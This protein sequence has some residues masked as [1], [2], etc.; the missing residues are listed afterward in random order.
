ME[1]RLKLNELDE[2]II[3]ELDHIVSI[4]NENLGIN[5]LE[6]NRTRPYIDGRKLLLGIMDTRYDL[7]NPGY[8]Y[9]PL[10]LKLLARYMGYR[11]HATAIHHIKD[12]E[13]LLNW[14]PSYKDIIKKVDSITNKNLLIRKEALEYLKESLLSQLED[15]NQKLSELNGSE[16][17]N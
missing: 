6:K 1:K 13:N 14:E 5:I 10:T 11:D 3:K 2:S 17:E 8:L 12:F 9:K 15:I 4:I 7:K 16:A